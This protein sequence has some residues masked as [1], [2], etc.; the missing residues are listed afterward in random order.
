VTSMGLG[1]ESGGG[2][3]NRQSQDAGTNYS[4]QFSAGSMRTMAWLLE[5]LGHWTMAA[6]Q[7]D[8]S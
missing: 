7:I 6:I 5:D 4:W 8:E 1:I 3:Q 2:E